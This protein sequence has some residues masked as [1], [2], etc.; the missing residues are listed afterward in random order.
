ML[1]GFNGFDVLAGEFID[2][3]LKRLLLL[4]LDGLMVG[5]ACGTIWKAFV[6][7]EADILNGPEDAGGGV[8]PS[9]D[10]TSCNEN[11]SVVRS[12]AMA[13]NELIVG[14][15]SLFDVCD[16]TAFSTSGSGIRDGDFVQGLVG[17]LGGGVVDDNMEPIC[18]RVIQYG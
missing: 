7:S 10:L 13:F 9:S 18:N 16:Q 14:T 4:V 5:G 15:P 3:G 12:S 8:P 1:V 6:T 17:C 11:G 2:E